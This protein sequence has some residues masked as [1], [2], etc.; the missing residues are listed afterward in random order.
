MKIDSADLKQMTTQEDLL[1]STMNSRLEIKR[2]LNESNAN[3]FKYSPSFLSIARSDILI[4]LAQNQLKA[5]VEYTPDASPQ[6]D[7]KAKLYSKY[8]AAA[9]SGNTGALF[10][11]PKFVSNLYMLNE[12]FRLLVGAES[13]GSLENRNKV[14]LQYLG[15]FDPQHIGH[16][17]VITSV[18][19]AMGGDS[20]HVVTHIMGNHPLKS[21]I[22]SYTQQ[23][24]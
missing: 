2:L 17:I 19:K 11:L 10:Q 16:R 22:T 21:G 5:N 7:W 15:T 14:H 12:F 24:L 13:S 8:H 23:I 4:R 9:L 1:W 3:V 6:N 20:T 18:L